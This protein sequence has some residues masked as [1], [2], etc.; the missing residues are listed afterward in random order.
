MS[1]T[2]IPNEIIST[3][4]SSKEQLNVVSAQQSHLNNQKRIAELTK[5]ELASQTNT[6]SVWR[7]CGRAFIKQDKQV[8][9][10]DL[11]S[12]EKLIVDQLSALDKKKV[13]LETTIENALKG[14]EKFR[15]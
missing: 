12:D 14:L 15:K 9:I 13:Y 10:D 7:S 8:Y 2:T 5:Q 6:D 3:L 4:Q 1:S 11:N